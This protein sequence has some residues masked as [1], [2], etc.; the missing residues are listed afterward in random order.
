MSMRTIVPVVNHSV[1]RCHELANPFSEWDGSNPPLPLPE[2]L[3]ADVVYG[4]E[5]PPKDYGEILYETKQLYD[6]LVNSGVNKA[7]ARSQ[8]YYKNLPPDI[9]FIS[10]EDN[11]FRG[12]EPW[13]A[14]EIEKI[15]D[16]MI[17]II[18]HVNGAL[19]N[20]DYMKATLTK[21]E[22]K[23]AEKEL[24]NYQ[25]VLLGVKAV[26]E[27]RHTIFLQQRKFNWFSNGIGFN[28]WLDTFG[29]MVELNTRKGLS[30]KELSDIELA[31]IL[32]HEF[33]HDF[34]TADS[35]RKG[36]FMNAYNIHKKVATP[37]PNLYLNEFFQRIFTDLGLEA[38]W[39]R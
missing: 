6:T 15:H 1:N 26:T 10:R 34:G 9:R 37:K 21:E 36:Y 28:Y 13:K 14:D 20:I 38:P 29:S 12:G 30:W 23:I 17:I 8:T 27:G 31:E 25:K 35:N 4:P 33:S 2:V 32:F 22:Y 16:A 3:P 7:W 18:R 11:W 39:N 24:N 19:D 5:L